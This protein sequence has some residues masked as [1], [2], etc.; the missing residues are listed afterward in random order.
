MHLFWIITL[1]LAIILILLFLAL[2]F[3]PAGRERIRNNKLRYSLG[4]VVWIVVAIYLYGNVQNT[5]YSKNTTNLQKSQKAISKE[6]NSTQK[7][8]SSHYSDGSLAK[9]LAKSESHSYQNVSYNDLDSNSDELNGKDIAI[10]G[11]VSKVH[12]EDG[13]YVLIVSM[14]NN[15]AE[16]VMV[17]VDGSSVPKDKKISK[18]D[19]LTIKG[20]GG[21]KQSTPNELTDGNNIPYVD[22]S[23]TIEFQ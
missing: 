19:Q 2:P 3:T 5:S 14:D 10:T 12:K 17:A 11:T 9:D 13:S 6:S 1:L 15:Q 21:G 8:S 20:T 18:G 4:L 7:E 22:C 16:N 23:E